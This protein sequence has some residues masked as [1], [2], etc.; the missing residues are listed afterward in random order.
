M[1]KSTGRAVSAAIHS[2]L[3]DALL[4]GNPITYAQL[5]SEA[6]CT[7]RSVRNYLERSVEIFGFPVE[8]IRGD[9]H[10]VFVRALVPPDEPIPTVVDASPLPAPSQSKDCFD[11]IGEALA[12]SLRSQSAAHPAPRSAIFIALRA[13]PSYSPAHSAVLS[14]FLAACERHPTT[15]VSVRVG[16][17]WTP[18][19]VPLAVVLRD[20][21]GIL[22]IFAKRLDDTLLV[23]SIA[24]CDVSDADDAIRD[25]EPSPDF[26]DLDPE[27]ID[28]ID[29]L[30]LPF[31][32]TPKSSSPKSRV[33]VHLRF[34]KDHSALARS[35]W[36]HHSQRLIAHRD[37]STELR[38]GPVDAN[39]AASLV[40]S[41]GKTVEVLGDKRLRKVVKKRSFVP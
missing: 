22:L 25:V 18:P 31:A 34:E 28:L 7:V 5:A 21:R 23:N 30:D 17:I 29:V 36:W 26:S 11:Q 9:G 13:L 15:T 14:R 24:L 27:S 8:R 6:D 32:V 20:I 19:I 2:R 12:Q 40:V 1:S 38:F 41:L 37:G 16:D 4:R 33:S 3:R 10:N 39:A 35:R